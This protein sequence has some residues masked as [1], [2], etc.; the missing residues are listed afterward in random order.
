MFELPLC[1]YFLWKHLWKQRQD[2]YAL[3]KRH[4]NRIFSFLTWMP[5]ELVTAL[6]RLR[7]GAMEAGQPL[8]RQEDEPALLKALLLRWLALAS[9]GTKFSPAPL[10]GAVLLF[11]RATLSQVALRDVAS[12]NKVQQLLTYTVAFLNKCSQEGLSAQDLRYW[13]AAIFQETSL[14]DT[15][16]SVLIASYTLYVQHV[17]PF[18]G[19][20]IK[21]TM[22][23]AL[24]KLQYTLRQGPI[25]T[26]GAIYTLLQSVRAILVDIG[27]RPPRESREALV[28]GPLD[29]NRTL[30]LIIQGV[31]LRGKGAGEKQ[32]VEVAND[33]LVR[34]NL[35]L[36]E[37]T[38][39]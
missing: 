15:S 9:G 16:L 23:L 6:V 4:V 27:F 32:V 12:S 25:A 11:N 26:W 22:I 30:P 5:Q 33:I 37:S 35:I 29:L 14:D 28:L 24:S 39:C 13:A 21:V 36:R 8:W 2:A 3:Y 20:G 19:N 31:K 17:E 34:A 18:S 7:R 38:V 1:C 10:V